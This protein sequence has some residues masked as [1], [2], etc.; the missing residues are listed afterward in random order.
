MCACITVLGVCHCQSMYNDNA[1]SNYIHNLF[2]FMLHMMF[3]LR[4]LLLILQM[5][6]CDVW[7][8]GGGGVFLV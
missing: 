6:L 2:L 8:G 1:V 4:V 5:L 7:G 3:V